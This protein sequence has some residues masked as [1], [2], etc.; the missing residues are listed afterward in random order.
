MINK[1]YYTLV[2]FTAVFAVA[3]IGRTFTAPTIVGPTLAPVSAITDTGETWWNP[4]TWGLDEAGQMATAQANA[5][6]ASAQAGMAAVSTQLGA[7]TA[8]SANQQL[9]IGLGLAA[10]GATAILLARR[11]TPAAPT[12][13]AAPAATAPAGPDVA[14]MPAPTEEQVA[15]SFA[16]QAANGQGVQRP[17]AAGKK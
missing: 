15:A 6:V 5:A 3:V 4:G 7:A 11:A 13:A 14:P 1:I 2:V 17:A 10:L 9:L 12:P 16:A 8:W